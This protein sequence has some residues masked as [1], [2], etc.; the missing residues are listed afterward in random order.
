MTCSHKMR[1]VTKYHSQV[2]RY[3]IYRLISF[4]SYI[5]RIGALLGV[6]NL[7]FAWEISL[8][9]ID[10]WNVQWAMSPIY[11][12]YKLGL[13]FFCFFFFTKS[14]WL[15]WVLERYTWNN[16]NL[17]KK[18]HLRIVSSNW[19]KI[20]WCLFIW[21]GAYITRLCVGIDLCS[22]TK[23]QVSVNSFLIT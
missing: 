11:L 7:S 4:I 3:I 17:H 23:R 20:L 6:Q 12:N 13:F 1:E 9:S 21:K 14:N 18:C 5:F 19:F 10:F 2:I 15:A 8:L 16:N 22:L